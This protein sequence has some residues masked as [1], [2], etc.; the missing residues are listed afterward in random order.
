MRAVPSLA[1]LLLTVAAPACAAPTDTVVERSMTDLAR[2]HSSV[3]LVRAYRARIAAVDAA[4][5]R[6]HAVLALNPNA[7]AEAVAR[8]RAERRLGPLDG[9]PILIKDNIETADPV[10]TTAGSLAL[11]TNVAAQDAPLVAR[12]RAVGAVILGKTNLSEWANIRSTRSTSGWSA[13]GGLTRNPY[14]LDR[15]AC[16]SS[17][18]SGAA[19]AASLAAAAIGTETD[20]SITCPSSMNGIVGLKPT[21]GLVSRHGIVPISHSQDTPGPM[22]R[23]V[24]DAALMLTAIAGTDTA[25]PAT[26]EADAHRAD[27]AAAL[28]PNA[29]RGVRVAVLR[30]A[31]GDDP[32]VRVLFEAALADLARAGAVLVDAKDPHAQK[33][34]SA[35]ELTVLMTELKADMNTY[36]AGTPAAV[37]TRTLADLIAFNRATPAE[38]RWFDQE[39]FEQ[40]E[41]TKGLAD[42]AYV[43][44]RADSL[45]MAGADGIDA[46]L[47][48]ANA[49]VLV[50]PTAFP[51]WVSDL[52]NGD[53]AG[54]VGG[55]TLAAVAGYPHLTVPMGAVEELPVGLSFIGPK[56][57]EAAL[58][59]DGYAYEQASHRRRPPS[60]RPSV[61]LP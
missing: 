49:T 24:R 17:S 6:L 54:D 43:K 34:L 58:L 47:R 21:V 31:V 52:V 35:A 26:A 39:L 1:L 41:A 56:W 32:K 7:E 50:A 33:G 12:L 36:L 46:I 28:R 55:G 20:G 8:D 60:Y 61:P 53:H 14:A 57:S 18:G 9:M 51:A 3:A 37:R 5:P 23:T 42:P 2:A 40:A 59:A 22:T 45:R 15:T 44:A 10:A 25:D 19:V 30:Y 29:L 16:G 48:A 13:T 38:T 27:Y 11:V 4:G